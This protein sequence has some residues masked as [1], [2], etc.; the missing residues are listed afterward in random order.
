MCIVL[1]V[2]ISTIR[3]H[4]SFSLS[5]S[6]LMVAFFSSNGM[7]GW[8]CNVALF[9]VTTGSFSRSINSAYVLQRERISY[10]ARGV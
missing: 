9:D 10:I 1:H 3:V 5:R 6:L 8:V 2:G 4:L 7:Q